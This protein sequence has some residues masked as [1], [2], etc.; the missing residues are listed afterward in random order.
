M[1]ADTTFLIDLLNGREDA[2]FFAKHNYVVTTAISIFE[3]FQG[4]KESEKKVAQNILE[5]LPVLSFDK[6]AA[7]LSANILKELKNKGLEIDPE[8]CMIAAIVL[9]N[10]SVILTKN[11]KHFQR[12]RGLQIKQY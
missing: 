9:I 7:I 5:E 3:L 1:I 2:K 11:V 8:D 6:Q 4:L 10:K 12:I